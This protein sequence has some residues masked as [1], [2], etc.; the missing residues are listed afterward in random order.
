M[1]FSYSGNPAN[2]TLDAVRFLVE[3]TNSQDPQLQN[4]EINWL[5]AQYTNVWKSAAY[6]AG[7]IAAKYARQVSKAVGDL[8]LEYQQRQQAYK[9]LRADL[10]RQAANR[11]ALPWLG[12]ISRSERQASRQDTD[13]IQPKF[14]KDQ[15]HYPAGMSSMDGN[16]SDVGPADEQG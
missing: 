9:D 13:L 12:G 1:S 10:L 8:R 5:I 4:E 3:D 6:A 15:F 14:T 7:N 16:Q 11:T 2:S